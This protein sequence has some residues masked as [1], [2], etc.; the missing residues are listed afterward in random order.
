[1]KNKLLILLLI[2]SFAATAQEDYTI[3][4]NGQTLKLALDKNY[5]TT[6]NGQ[7]ISFIVKQNDILKYDDKDLSFDYPKDFTISRKKIDEDIDQ[8]AIVTGEGAGVIVQH[9]STINPMEFKEIMLNE[10]T[11]E[12]VNY[13]FVLTRHDYKKKLSSGQELEVVKAI[14]KYKDEINI[15]EITAHG[16]KDEGF[17]VMTM[18]MDDETDSDG[19]KLINMMWKTLMIK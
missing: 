2:S 3:Q 6:V 9:Y 10:V 16:K 17:I 11:K 12:S 7:K 15:Y 4:I 18:R 8:M 14:L 5:E 13:G 1:M 19:M